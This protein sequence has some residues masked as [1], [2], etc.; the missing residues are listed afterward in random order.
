MAADWTFVGTWSCAPRWFDT[1]DGPMHYVDEWPR[2]GRLVV[3]LRGNPTCG[4]L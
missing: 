2:D 1:A 4:Y 3:L